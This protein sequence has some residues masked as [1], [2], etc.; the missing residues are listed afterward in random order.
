[1]IGITTAIE[2]PSGDRVFVGI[3]Y[4]VPINAAQR[5]LPEMLRGA[6]IEHPR[7][8]VALQD[9]T[10]G[11]ASS[12]GLDVDDGVLITTVV[13]GSAADDAGLRGGLSSGS[14]GDVIVAIDGTPVSTFEDLACYIDSK[15]VGDRIEVEIVRGGRHMTLPLTLEAWQ[16]S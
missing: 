10:P 12:L 2:N 1:M 4:A 11:L 9:V 5:F 7:M 6:T 14:I 16:S 13:S 8:G 15:D 3:G